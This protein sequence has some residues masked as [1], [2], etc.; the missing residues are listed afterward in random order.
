MDPS[1]ILNALIPSLCV[2]ALAAWLTARQQDKMFRLQLKTQAGA[3]KRA[4]KRQVTTERRIARRQ[5]DAAE[6]AR[7]H[8][9]EAFERDATRKGLLDDYAAQ[10]AIYEEYVALWRESYIGPSDADARN[11]RVSTREACRVRAMF[12]FSDGEVANAI[13]SALVDAEELNTR[14]TAAVPLDGFNYV[15]AANETDLAARRLMSARIE[16][17]RAELRLVKPATGAPK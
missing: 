2:T 8:Q 17:I 14:R 1:P 6:L 16:A 15:K 3:E 4:D 12:A 11:E 10:R 5:V 13:F 7:E 9:R